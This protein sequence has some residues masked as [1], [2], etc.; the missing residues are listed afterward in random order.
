[1]TV[2]LP[3][4]SRATTSAEDIADDDRW[5]HRHKAFQPDKPFYMYWA[6]GVIHGRHHIMKEWA[7]QQ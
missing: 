1:M 7:E 4:R 6:S 2:V 3:P 5:L